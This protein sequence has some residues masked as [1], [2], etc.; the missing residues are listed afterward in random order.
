[1]K[2]SEL[3]KI[4]KEIILKEAYYE[5]L[6]K[7]IVKKVRNINGWAPSR[8][9]DTGGIDWEHKKYEY[10]IVAGSPF[11]DDRAEFVLAIIDYSPDG[12]DKEIIVAKQKIKPTNNLETDAKKFIDFFKKNISKAEKKIKELM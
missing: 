5:D 10:F 8:N 1:M 7:Y 2:R 6:T 11:F 4:I 9:V 12:S 3:K